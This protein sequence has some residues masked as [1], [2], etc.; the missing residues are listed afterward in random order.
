MVVP[1]LLDEGALQ[2]EDVN[3]RC[4]GNGAPA[5]CPWTV[6]ALKALSDEEFE[7]AA[8]RLFCC[9]AYSL[10]Y[11]KNGTI[12]GLSRRAL[13]FPVPI[14][15]DRP[16]FR[17][18]SAENHPE[19]SPN[20]GGGGQNVLFTDGHVSF[21]KGRAFNGDDIF[22]N[23]NNRVAAGLNPNDTVLGISEARPVKP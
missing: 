1:I 15:A 2:R 14:M 18:G 5:G 22:L 19:N 7:Q 11:Q 9:Y 13:S 21:L 16:P 17:E 4:P 3:V 12:H 10:G 6:D 20:H 8:P 23:Q